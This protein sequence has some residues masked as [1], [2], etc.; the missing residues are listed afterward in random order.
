MGVMKNSPKI[1][2][3]LESLSPA[4]S[5]RNLHPHAGPTGEKAEILG[6]GQTVFTFRTI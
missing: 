1:P 4:V 3:V 6:T 5:Q 2:G